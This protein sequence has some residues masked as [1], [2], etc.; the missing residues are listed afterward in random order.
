M[1]DIA[2]S[3]PRLFLCVV[4]PVH[5]TSPSHRPYDRP[6]D[7]KY[8]MNTMESGISAYAQRLTIRSN[9]KSGAAS[10]ITTSAITTTPLVLNH[11][12]NAVNG[13]SVHT[14]LTPRYAKNAISQKLRRKNTAQSTRRRHNTTMPRTINPARVSRSVRLPSATSLLVA[15]QRLIGR[16]AARSIHIV[17]SHRAHDA[18][19]VRLLS[20]H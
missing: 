13:T 3:A 20:M 10:L 7:G 2:H 8:L 16:D 5:M 18:R 9:A 19:G 6:N 17:G 12:L 14:M 15:S 4:T 11:R 1:S